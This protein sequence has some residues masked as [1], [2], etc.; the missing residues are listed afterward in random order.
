M[1]RYQ[2][3]VDANGQ[4][5]M[6][7]PLNLHIGDYI[8]FERIGT[9]REWNL[10]LGRVVSFPS[11]QTV[12]VLHYDPCGT[13]TVAQDPEDEKEIKKQAQKHDR[14]KV[15]KAREELK[16]KLK[17]AVEEENE[18]SRRLFEGR[19]ETLRKQQAANAAMAASYANLDAAR[20]LLKEH[21]HLWCCLRSMIVPPSDMVPVVKALLLVLHEDKSLSSW[22]NMRVV[23]MRNDFF[24][25]LMDTDCA[26]KPMSVERCDRIMELLAEKAQRIAKLQ[27]EK[28]K[29]E[30]RNAGSRK[31]TQKAET[32][33]R[34]LVKANKTNA[35]V[36]NTNKSSSR[37]HECKHHHPHGEFEEDIGIMHQLDV[38]V[39][40]WI[41]VQVQL[42]SAGESR[43]AIIDECFTEQQEQRVTLRE[44]NDMRANIS[45]LEEEMLSKKKL[46]L[47]EKDNRDVLKLQVKD[48]PAVTTFHRRT[49]IENDGRYVHLVVLRSGVIANFGA[50]VGCENEQGYVKLGKQQT[51]MLRNRVYIS[52]IVHDADTMEDLLN[53]TDQNEKELAELQ[54][55][56]DVL[57]SKGHLSP[58][59]AEELTQLTA[60]YEE[61][62]RQYRATLARIAHMYACCRGARDITVSDK[63]SETK[64]LRLGLKWFGRWGD[65]ARRCATELQRTL[66][67]DLSQVVQ[68]EMLDSV[69]L[70][71]GKT[72]LTPGQWRP[73]HRKR[74][75]A[76]RL[77]GRDVQV[78]DEHLL[79]NFNIKYTGPLSETELTH[80]YQH[81]AY[82]NVET[83]YA[84]H[85]NGETTYP[86]NTIQQEADCAESI[87]KSLMSGMPAN[88]NESG[89]GPA[90]HERDYRL[91]D[92]S[93]VMH[94]D[95]ATENDPDFRKS[96]VTIVPAREDFDVTCV[97]PPKNFET[98]FECEDE[99]EE[100]VVTKPSYDEYGEGQQEV[101]EA[102][103]EADARIKAAQ[104]RF[105]E[106]R[107]RCEERIR[108]AKEAYEAARLAKE[109][110]EKD[111]AEATDDES[112]KRAE[113]ARDKAE[114]E[115][116]QAQAEE[117]EARR[118]LEEATR[119]LQE[120]EED[121]RRYVDDA[122]QRAR[123]AAEAA[124]R[125]EEEARRRAEEAEAKARKEQAEAEE[126]LEKAAEAER[127]VRELEAKYAEAE[128]KTDEAE[129]RK[130]EAE[131]KAEEKNE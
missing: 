87:G 17:K 70:R 29:E 80:L 11:S 32:N 33:E 50:L 7:D 100:T 123:E 106:I 51:E 130:E 101:E 38:A 47:G 41:E 54:N 22:E 24:K 77:L 10:A 103:R 86:I 96:K 93:H 105:E 89:A 23:M 99:P 124:R 115:M 116:R 42:S 127:K 35:T 67:E 27:A 97:H 40:R 91:A 62:D 13:N 43:N 15:Y 8:G 125:A 69:A 66:V 55:R 36:A 98:T 95:S 26:V 88:F 129:E 65:I 59:E 73:L 56:I 113:E 39:R 68:V 28:D 48:Y 4:L 34:Q 20:K 131:E 74:L 6:G 81:G 104:E 2:E 76:K 30:K 72:D 108:K 83:F 31:T 45:M 46:I 21:M 128:K 44:V 114:E 18:A 92:G 9:D 126:A 94:F 120:A 25:R 78:S 121:A 85:R 16:K 49:Y 63:K 60:V 112:R 117:D 119:Q 12:K 71:V 107:Q 14:M 90:P 84:K 75:C 37:L 122:R 118:E 52:N 19:A 111:I 79:V 57:R 82:P 53:I 102:E 64:Y 1:V 3:P 58:E 5:I 110:A 61:R 109:Q